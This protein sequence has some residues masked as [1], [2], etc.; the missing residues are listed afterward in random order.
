M[1]KLLLTFGTGPHKEYLNQVTRKHMIEYANKHGYSY[2]EPNIDCDYFKQYNRPSSWY[3]LLLFMRF[4]E[5][6]EN[7][8]W[9]DAD[10]LIKDK[11][12]DVL[13]YMEPKSLQGMVFHQTYSE[14][15]VP[16]CGLWIVNHHIHPYLLELWDRTDIINNSWWE[17]LAVTQY[18]DKNKEF[19]NRTTDL[20]YRFNY[21]KFDVRGMP[22]DT[23]F[24][25]A[26]MY[27]DR[28]AQLKEWDSL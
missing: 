13:D 20:P 25:H 16:N 12:E 24:Y 18:M 3:K 23:A 6:Y 22:L 28:L 15:V 10:I 9:V 11:T 21:H 2:Y 1:R 4:L 19:K 7:I 26:T 8:L 5:E 14:G 17:Q 27:Q